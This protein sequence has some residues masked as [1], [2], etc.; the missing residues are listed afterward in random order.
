MTSILVV[1]LFIIVLYIISATFDYPL[2]F[3]LF[4]SHI[5]W[6]GN[7]K[8]KKVTLTFDDGPHPEYTPIILEI[9]EKYNIKASFFLV[10]E[11][12][13][14]YPELVKKQYLAGHT[15]GIHSYSHPYLPL[16]SNKRLRYE[17]EETAKQLKRIIGLDIKYSR[18]PYGARDFRFYNLTKQLNYKV[19]MWSLASWDWK[20]KNPEKII[21][22][23]LGEVNNGAIILLQQ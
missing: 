17:L 20:A 21:N 2:L 6:R 16:V 19:I 22:K 23:V 1:I 4:Y 8:E 5:I 12:I 3:E 18:P 10:G 7:K 13:I 14:K 15:L 11:N 9:L